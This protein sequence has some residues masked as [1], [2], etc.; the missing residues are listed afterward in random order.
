MTIF[1]YSLNPPP[2]PLI[3]P[4]TSTTVVLMS[5][6][7]ALNFYTKFIGKLHINV[8]PFYELLHE[9]NPWKQ[10]DDYESL[11]QKLKMSLT[12]E[13]ELT[14]PNIKH[15][16]FITVGASLIGLGVVLFQLNEEN[17]MKVTSYNSR[18]LNPQEQ[19][20]ST[21]DRDFLGIVHA[22]QTYEFLSIC[23]LHPLLI[24]NLFYNV[25][26]KKVTLAHNFTEL[27]C[28]FQNF[29][30]SK[31]LILLEKISLLLIC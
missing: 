13:T 18:I 1:G 28:T 3:M 19:N 11:F 30:N 31:S 21:L 2:P 10:T 14:I 25:F 6:I 9:N 5:F 7:G 17:K 15:P 24:I 8:K 27:N 23:S 26:T 20:I 4:R 12:S 29:Q 22:L 16:I